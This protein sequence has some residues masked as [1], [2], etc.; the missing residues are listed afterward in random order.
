MKK[1]RIKLKLKE[2]NTFDEVWASFKECPDNLMYKNLRNEIIKAAIELSDK[3]YLT[4]KIS[5][6]RLP[7]KL[8]QMVYMQMLEQTRDKLKLR[9][10]CLYCE[11]KFPSVYLQAMRKREKLA[12][13]NKDFDEAIR[14][15]IDAESHPIIQNH[16]LLLSIRLSKNR[17]DCRRIIAIAKPEF[18]AYDKVFQKMNSMNH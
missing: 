4:E 7:P 6:E 2:A 10:I 14:I 5:I 11:T 12:D 9:A 17:E 13:E 8:L 15:A 1:K 18:S 16:V 3:L